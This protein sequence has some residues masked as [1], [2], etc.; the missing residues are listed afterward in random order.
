MQW[1]PEMRNHRPCPFRSIWTP[2]H[3]TP[4]PERRP[5]L[6]RVL[7]VHNTIIV[8]APNTSDCVLFPLECPWGQ[9]SC[10]KCLHPICHESR[11]L[12]SLHLR[13]LNLVI[14][15]WGS[16]LIRTGTFLPLRCP[17][18]KD[19]M[20]ILFLWDEWWQN[21]SLRKRHGDFISNM[22]LTEC[23]QSEVS[24][25]AS[26]F[27]F[28]LHGGNPPKA[29]SSSLSGCP[30]QLGMLACETQPHTESSVHLEKQSEIWSKLLVCHRRGDRFF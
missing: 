10:E 11:I 23:C 20:T 30:L 29:A 21:S 22:K 5:G 14:S 17:L 25:G 7:L 1:C 6:G 16:L 12:A 2:P 13:E 9:N 26:C 24:A 15:L 3:L 18:T 28:C 19:V 8:K 27:I 4:T